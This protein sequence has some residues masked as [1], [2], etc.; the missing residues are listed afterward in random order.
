MSTE[1]VTAKAKETWNAVKELLEKAE[2]TVQKELSKAAPA[3]QKSL[4]SSIEAAVKGFIST[5]NTI[6]TRTAKERMELLRAYKRFLSGQVGY[7][8]SRIGHSRGARRPRS[9]QPPPSE[10]ACFLPGLFWRSERP[11]GAQ[12]L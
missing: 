6:D 11:F 5:M 2:V 4:E 1:Q 10:R 8:D 3:V 7:V 9:R 12:A